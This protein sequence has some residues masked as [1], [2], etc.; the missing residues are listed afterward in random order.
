M[1]L[2]ILFP[3]TNIAHS[4][5]D[6]QLP[7]KGRMPKAYW[8]DNDQKLEFR[9][10]WH[11]FALKSWFN[12]IFWTSN[13]IRMWRACVLGV[14]GYDGLR[15]GHAPPSLDCLGTNKYR[16]GLL[17]HSLIGIRSS[18]DSCVAVYSP[19]HRCFLH[20]HPSFASASQPAQHKTMSWV[21]M[22]ITV[23]SHYTLLFNVTLRIWTAILSFGHQIGF[24]VVI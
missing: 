14:L 1:P 9:N 16:K 17:S 13:K 18:P 5:S 20:F 15:S 10:Q 11:V 6:R 4:H 3:K 19:S 8:R 7:K 2:I 22:K 23:T 24:C 21:P 12:H